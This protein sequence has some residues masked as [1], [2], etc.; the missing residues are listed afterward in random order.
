MR[1]PEIPSEILLGIVTTLMTDKHHS[2]AIKPRPTANDCGVVAERT[3]TMQLDE[4]RED[5]RNVVEHER[6]PYIPGDL[7]PLNGGEMLVHVAPQFTELALKRH[8]LVVDVYGPL[9]RRML[10]LLDLPLELCDGLLEVHRRRTSCHPVSYTHLR[11][12][13]TGRNL[14]CRL[15][16]E[17]KKKK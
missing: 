12:H 9:T 16:L 1:H 8:N 10:Q 11:A 4:I 14:V 15:L 5:P 2:F 13:E 3:V 7:H 6:S 17:K